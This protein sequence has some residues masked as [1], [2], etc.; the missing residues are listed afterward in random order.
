M[1][2]RKVS[3][4][5]LP[6]LAAPALADSPGLSDLLPPPGN[7]PAPAVPLDSGAPWCT[8]EV[9]R[10]APPGGLL[11]EHTGLVLHVCRDVIGDRPKERQGPQRLYVNYARVPGLTFEHYAGRVWLTDFV[12]YEGDLQGERGWITYF[13]PILDRRERHGGALYEVWRGPPAMP[14]VPDPTDPTGRRKITLYGPMPYSTGNTYV[15]VPEPGTAAVPAHFVHCHTEPKSIWD[16]EPTSC[17]VKINYRGRAAHVQLFGAGPG[18]GEDS[19]Y[20]EM[21]P[22]FP[23]F[24]R[25]IYALLS[26][27]DATD[28]PAR[29]DCVREGRDW[30]EEGCERGR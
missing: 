21:H 10:G 24:A 1:R 13:Y 5:I 12:S 3:L 6:L 16:D 28:D 8:D 14:L 30:R 23:H 25:D 4:C 22:L 27:V 7:V 26:A 9:E 18:Y 2:S 20:V 29:Q 17:F 19:G 11:M 15:F